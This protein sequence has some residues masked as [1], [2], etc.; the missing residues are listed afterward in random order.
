M[1]NLEHASN[2]AYETFY[3][4]KDKGGHPYY[5]HCY[6]V[7]QYTKELGGTEEEQIAAILHDLVEDTNWTL[8]D[9]RKEGFSDRVVCLVDKLTR[10]KGI[11]YMDY[12]RSITNS[13]DIGLIKIKL[14]D[15]K[16]NSDPERINQ[17][18]ESERSIII[19]Y[20]KAR[21]LL[22]QALGELR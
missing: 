20:N 4:V 14:A 19:R 1:S 21:K 6:R 18:P 17:L 15:N 10:P 2:I 11:T 22:E 7:S 16:D 9:L 3:G 13:G 8:E 5:D 12:I